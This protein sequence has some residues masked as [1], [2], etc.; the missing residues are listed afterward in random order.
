MK[1]RPYQEECVEAIKNRFSHGINRQLINLPTA[2]GKTVIFANLI[3]QMNRKTL[4][5]AHTGELIGQAKEKIEM[6][7]PGLDLGIV[8]ANNKQFEKSVVI[9]SIQSARQQD[10][11][12]ELQKQGFTL[13]IYDEAHRAAADSPKQILSSLGFMESSENL[14]VGF[15][16]TPFRRDNKGL[17]EVFSEVTYSKTIKDLIALGYLC[18]PVGIKIATDLDLSRV[19]TANGDF[20]AA[21]LASV[22]NTPEMNELVANSY[23][24]RAIDRKAVCF[25]VTVAHA[26]N[27]A[28]TFKNRG[29]AAEAIYGDMPAFE[30]AETLKRFQNGDIS[31]LTN[32][33]ILTEGWNCPEVDCIIV[34]KPTESKG[35]FIQM[36]GRGLRLYPNKKDC[37]ILDFGSQSHSLCSVA[38][39]T[40]EIEGEKPKDRAE[41]KISEFAQTLPPT[42]NKKLK[43][44]ILKFD[45]LGDAFTWIKEGAGYSLKATGDKLL[46]IM[47]AIEDRYNVIF[48]TGNNPRII[49]KELS[50]EYAFATA[51]G[52]AK[53]NRSSFIVSDLDASWRNQ[54]ISDKQKGLF[55][56]H[57]YRSG[58]EELSRGQASL[59][60]GSG[61][62]KRKAV[63]L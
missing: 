62:L 17:K 41:S 56:S 51:E 42:I 28:E 22:M 47:P 50:F 34:A 36:A 1:L 60:I 61:V 19:T 30:R 54:P 43:A 33:Q 11:L 58:I 45:P 49:A 3:Q 6:I 38:A 31:V 48:F 4:V 52:F 57:G 2:A 14:L 8:N 46:K 25:S 37:L 39:L 10:N 20:V 24:Q 16:A 23:I 53:E 59:I 26:Q 55:R 35:L 9:S 15:T 12:A 18:K 5:L 7:C 29:I 63:R 27:L 32:C 40:G 44:A 21:S 13:C